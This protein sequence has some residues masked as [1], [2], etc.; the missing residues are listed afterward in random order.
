MDNQF[1]TITAQGKDF[2]DE[3]TDTS[4]LGDFIRPRGWMHFEGPVKVN[5]EET[6]Y[7]AEYNNRG[8]GA[9]FNARVN[10]KGYYKIDRSIAMKFTI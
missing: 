4:A 1:N 10:W 2:I 7:Y 5:F 6:L 3:N 8:L 9:N